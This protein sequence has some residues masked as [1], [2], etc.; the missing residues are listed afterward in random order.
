METSSKFP[1]TES[2]ASKEQHKRKSADV[3]W[4]Y[5]VLADL[6]NLDRVKCILCGKVMSGG[7][8]RLKHHIAQITGNVTP[9]PKSTLEDQIKCRNAI[10]ENKCKKKGK[11]DDDDAL[12]AS[13]KISDDETIDLDENY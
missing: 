1:S 10:N 2:T 8:N 9:C 12:R 6:N 13:V 11:Q 5:A 3:G 7:I 4:E